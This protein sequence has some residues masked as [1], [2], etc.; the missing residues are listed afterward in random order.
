[1]FGFRTNQ[2]AK[3]NFRHGCAALDERDHELASCWFSEAIRV[4]GSFAP[5]HL[6]L[7]LARMRKGEFLEAIRPL[8]EAIRLSDDPRAW[9]L[10]GLCHQAAGNLER[11]SADRTAAFARNLR[12]EESLA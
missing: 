2:Y 11:G 12:V 3:S 10:R 4:D 1:M 7:G 6:G 9:F 5:G 8:S